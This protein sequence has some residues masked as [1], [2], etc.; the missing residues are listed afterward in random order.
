MMRGWSLTI[1]A[2]LTIAAAAP[3]QVPQF[4]WQTGQVLTYRVSQTTTAVETVKDGTLTTTTQ[5]DLV[6][7]WQV[8][9]VDAAGTATLQM[10]LAS[11]RMETKPPSGD[12]ILFDSANLATSHE[13]LREEMQKYI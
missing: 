13:Q 4:R 7:R 9:A 2:V 10:T 3:A 5:L 11:L 1:F 6:K 12:P 8:V